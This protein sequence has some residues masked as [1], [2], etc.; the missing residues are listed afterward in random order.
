MESFRAGLKSFC[1]RKYSKHICQ[2]LHN[3]K[4]ESND[5]HKSLSKDVKFNGKPMFHCRI[6]Q[7]LCP[8]KILATEVFRKKSKS[9]FYNICWLLENLLIYGDQSTFIKTPLQYLIEI[10]NGF[11][12]FIV[13]NPATAKKVILVVVI[14]YYHRR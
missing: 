6:F 2:I 7:Q 10:D 4:K 11:W 14:I 3:G 12:L 5:I 13:K 1:H 9:S 8:D